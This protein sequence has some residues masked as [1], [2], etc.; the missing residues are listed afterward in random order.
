MN[1]I[2]VTLPDGSQR[3]LQEGATI[4]DLAASIG[5]GLAKAAIAGKIDGNLVDLNTP[6]TDG[7]RVEIVTEKSPEA[8]TIIRHSTSHLMVSASGQIGRAH[9]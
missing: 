6:L 4:Y 9:V 7:A 2:K 1:E 8:L 5:A 3:P